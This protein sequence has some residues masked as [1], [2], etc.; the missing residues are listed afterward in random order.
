VQPII[1][2]FLAPAPVRKDTQDPPMLL[3]SQQWLSFPQANS[4]QE[5]RPHNLN[6]FFL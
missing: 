6:Q 1:E 4:Y 2:Q 3:P 5:N